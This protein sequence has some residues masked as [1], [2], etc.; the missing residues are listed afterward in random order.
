MPVT[1]R[2]APV[3]GEAAEGH[4]LDLLVD[5]EAVRDPFDIDETHG[6][7]RD[8]QPDEQQREKIFFYHRNGIHY[9]RGG[10]GRKA[11]SP[12]VFDGKRLVA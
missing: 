5:L 3:L 6:I 9:K 12:A 1:Q 10:G 4:G 8:G 2:V 11:F 7:D